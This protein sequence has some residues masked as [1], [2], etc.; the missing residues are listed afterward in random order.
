MLLQAFRRFNQRFIPAPATGRHINSNR[1]PSP[2][3][4]T[5]KQAR[6]G[7][8]LVLLLAA[9]YLLFALVSVFA[10]NPPAKPTNLTAVP[11]D[12]I[13]TLSWHDPDDSSI[14]KY[15]FRHTYTIP[16]T[17]GDV[18]PDFTRSLWTTIPNSGATPLSP[19]IR[20]LRRRAHG[21][22]NGRH[23]GNYA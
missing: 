20:S 21:G 22:G 16:E 13:A 23:C 19:V 15:E 4:V 5:F 11:G 12:S 9:A 2:R 10:N 7:I 6:W 18:A 1:G 8:L 14:T 17:D 3:A